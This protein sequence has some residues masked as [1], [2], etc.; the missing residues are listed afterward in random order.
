[1]FATL[2]RDFRVNITFRILLIILLGYVV[3]VILTQ[4]H[5]WLVSLWI[6]L[7]IVTL[8]AELLRYTKKSH[9]ELENLLIAIR[10]GDF[11]SS[12]KARLPSL[13]LKQSFT[14]T[15]IS[16][17]KLRQ[18]QETNHLYLQNVVEHANV[19]LI[20]FDEHQKIQ[21]INQAAKDLLQKPFIREL[22][23][24]QA[25][26]TELF[27]T[28]ARLDSGE[29]A[30]VKVIIHTRLLNLLI[31]ATEFKLQ[32]RYFKLISL[33][34]FR[35]ELEEQEIE[36]WQ[37]LIRVLTHE[38][39]NSAI[40]IA[41]LSGMVNQMLESTQGNT[42]YRDLSTLDAEE[43]ED[44]HGSLQTIENRS[45]G[46]ANFVKAYRSLTQMAEPHFSEIRITELFSRLHTLLHP[47][48]VE[49]AITFHQ[50]VLPEN[51]LLKADPE[52]LEQMLINLLLNAMDA[53]SGVASPAPS[54][55][56]VAR[57]NEEGKIEIQ[58]RDNGKGIEPEII[59]Q[60]FVPFYTTK[61]EGSGV[62]L[63]LSRQIMRVHK[64][65]ISVRSAPG[66][67]TVF[68]LVF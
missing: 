46:L 4:T 57:K 32:N 39:M 11:S 62:G 54:M 61:K 56:I 51:L 16:L 26:D 19:A 58:V 55:G 52:L 44:L 37:K 36:S 30:L 15:M 18:E 14:E 5:F 67:G 42:K 10:Q 25:L 38:I 60:I 43:I 2:F 13:T 17:R 63:S 22:A 9:K 23:D 53:F 40:P 41:N 64:G 65:S 66:Q 35:T 48:L 27:G 47:K 7:L 1:M 50:Q 34:D 3:V 24:L 68:T 33:Q 8:T 20:C 45:K 6:G 28:I 12:Y 59:D 31:Q 21:L 49:T 29:K